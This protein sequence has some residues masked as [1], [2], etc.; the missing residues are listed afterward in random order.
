MD[1]DEGAADP[2]GVSFLVQSGDIFEIVT[3]FCSTNF[4]F[5]GSA[6][7]EEESGSGGIHFELWLASYRPAG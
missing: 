3:L 6:A 7:V 1:N 4:S 2:E 5:L